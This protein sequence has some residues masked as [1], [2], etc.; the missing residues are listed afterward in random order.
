MSQ[1]IFMKPPGKRHLPSPSIHTSNVVEGVG[2]DHSLMYL[3]QVG[4]QAL[5]N[6]MDEENYVDGA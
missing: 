6:P 3:S 5:W 2:H 4:M 1:Q